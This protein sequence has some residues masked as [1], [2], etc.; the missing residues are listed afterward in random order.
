MIIII[1]IQLIILLIAI[2]V[3]EY[4][5]GWVAYKLGDPTAKYSGRLS[6]NPLAH[7]DPIGTVLLPLTMVMLR[8]PPIGWAKPVPIN[9]LSLKNPKKDMLWVGIA[10]PCANFLTAFFIA[11]IIK[12]PAIRGSSLLI[13]LLSLGVLINLILGVF[14]LIPIPPLDGS[15]M[16]S[17]LLPWKYAHIYSRI[18]PYGFVIIIA[19]LWL[20]V[21]R[22][23][24]FPL[25]I[26]LGMFLGADFSFL[27]R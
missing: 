18:E 6:I 27:F 4:A 20:G 2:T 14:N 25:V 12:L 3:H 19:L 23:I 7:I 24:I 17:S 13:Q 16:V 22:A 9:F 15:R 21:L 1:I 26:K 10:G 5:H 11:L 8:L